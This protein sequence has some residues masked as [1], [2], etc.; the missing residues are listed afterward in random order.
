MLSLDL[1]S[2]ARLQSAAFDS[3]SGF[4]VLVMQGSK[5]YT[6]AQ[7]L[8]VNSAGRGLV[9]NLSAASGQDRFP[10]AEDESFGRIQNVR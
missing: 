2:N 5:L 3:T 6:D 9:S 10:T 1:S 4:D 7:T 8:T